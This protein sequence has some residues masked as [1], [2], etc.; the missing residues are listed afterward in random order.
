MPPGSSAWTW[1][2]TGVPASTVMSSG[3]V[4]VGGGSLTAASKVSSW[5][6]PP[7]SVSERNILSPSG[8]QLVDARESVAEVLDIGPVFAEMPV[9]EALRDDVQD[10]AARQLDP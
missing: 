3:T 1:S 2:V 10:A 5:M 8:L 7:A 9:E 6:L 4:S